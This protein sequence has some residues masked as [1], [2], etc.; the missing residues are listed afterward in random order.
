M[1]PIAF[2]AGAGIAYIIYKA[3]GNSSDSINKIPLTP[4]QMT[5]VAKTNLLSAEIDFEVGGLEK[6]K[7]T[8][9][10]ML[11]KLK[12]AVAIIREITCEHMPTLIGTSPEILIR[13]NHIGYNVRINWPA[14]FAT[15]RS[16][17]IRPS[18]QDCIFN[19]IK[20]RLEPK[21]FERIKSF[22]IFRD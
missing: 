1:K 12:P 13:D 14:E 22:R 16:G 11:N 8:H 20:A 21:T 3:V 15:T 6:I 10:Y 2:I 18:V 19:K 17:L 7:A 4:E 5:K 9:T